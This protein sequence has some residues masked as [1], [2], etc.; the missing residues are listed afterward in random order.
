MSLTWAGFWLFLAMGTSVAILFCG[1]ME[2]RVDEYA[3][4]LRANCG[5][6]IEGGSEWLAELRDPDACWGPED[7][8]DPAGAAP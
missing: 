1:E 7:D 2:A 3:D 8:D 4:T 6:E 5:F